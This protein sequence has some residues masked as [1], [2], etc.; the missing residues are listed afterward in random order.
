MGFLTS[1]F[2][3]KK[4]SSNDDKTSRGPLFVSEAAYQKNRYKQLGM[5]QQTMKHLRGYGVT[6]DS[7]L[8]LE[9][10]FYPNA[11]AKAVSFG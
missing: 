6:D 10:F 5:S 3:C 8:K 2:G 7:E 1:L 9:Y 11:K 4:S